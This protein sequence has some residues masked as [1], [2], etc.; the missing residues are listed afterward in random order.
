MKFFLTSAGISNPSI[1]SAFLKLIGKPFENSSLLFIPTAANVEVDKSYVDKDLNALKNLNFKDVK[2]VDIA[3]EK[4]EV[5]EQEIN[6]AG[7]VWFSGGNTFYL[8][9]QFRQTGLSKIL[10]QLLINKIYGGT[11]AGSIVA[12]PSIDVANVEPGDTNINNITDLSG[13]NLVDFEVSPHTYSYVTIENVAKYAASL[14]R[15]LYAID[16][17]SAVS[18]DGNKV[19]VISEGQ[20]Q[21][22][23]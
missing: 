19:E 21:K 5:V 6:N 2:V 8:L 4:P 16:D 11:S 22:F 17:Q 23:N 1:A 7:V 20:W 13:L 14:N 12:T 3:V 15:T 10:P 18:V 9:E